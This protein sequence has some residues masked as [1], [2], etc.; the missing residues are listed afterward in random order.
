M[1]TFTIPA[2]ILILFAIILAGVA[3]GMWMVLT[4]TAPKHP[5][6]TVK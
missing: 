3:A 6:E 4:Y 2:F 5:D 1:F